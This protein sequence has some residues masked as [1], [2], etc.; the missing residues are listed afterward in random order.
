MV[1]RKAVQ[2]AHLGGNAAEVGMESGVTSFL[3]RLRC[4][5]ASCRAMRNIGR[6]VAAGAAVLIL[7]SGCAIHGSSRTSKTAAPPTGVAVDEA[8]AWHARESLL[9]QRRY[10]IDVVGVR[11]LA[12]GWMLQMR[13]RVL[14]P[15]KAAPFANEHLRPF[16]IHD[17]SGAKLAVPSMENIGELRQSGR[18]KSDR[19]YYM[20]FGNANQLVQ[21]GDHVTVVVGSARVEGLVVE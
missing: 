7:G 15:T 14:D 13:Y 10:G 17:K 20:L 3:D 18:L 6:M 19:D 11:R 5:N 12:S 4:L 8:G 2:E 9:V 1:D 21:S 16:L